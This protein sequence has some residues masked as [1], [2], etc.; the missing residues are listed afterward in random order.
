MHAAAAC[1]LLSIAAA[2]S[3]C[4]ADR[5]AGDAHPVQGV[6]PAATCAADD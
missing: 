5:A 4:R 2:L 6:V 3:A 1:L